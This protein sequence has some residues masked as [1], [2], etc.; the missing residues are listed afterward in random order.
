[1][2]RVTGLKVLLA[3]VVLMSVCGVKA[4]AD[5]MPL[6]S[7]F[8]YEELEDGW[9]HY[10]SVEPV[11]KNKLKSS[12]MVLPKGRLMLMDSNQTYIFKYEEE[13][14]IKYSPS[15]REYLSGGNKSVEGSY[16]VEGD[17]LILEGLAT[18]KIAISQ[19]ETVIEPPPVIQLTFTTDIITE[20]LKG[21][22]LEAFGVVSRN[23]NYDAN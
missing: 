22:M 17:T 21:Q 11:A 10:A 4:K 14:V 2:K 18:G 13:N 8:L 5:D 6:L 12:G 9:Y 20:G 19:T 1:M 3:A 23:P 7:R 15:S 16:R